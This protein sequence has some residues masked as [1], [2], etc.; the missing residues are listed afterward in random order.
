MRSKDPKIKGPAV[1]LGSGT[2][3]L[4]DNP[5]CDKW[6]PHFL[7]QLFAFAITKISAYI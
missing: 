2:F 5:T 6:K 4:S 3:W 7:K 1:V